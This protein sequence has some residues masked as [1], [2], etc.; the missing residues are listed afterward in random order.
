M[1]VFG[2][3]VVSDRQDQFRP[4]PDARPEADHAERKSARPHGV[5]ARRCARGGPG[6]RPVTARAPVHYRVSRGASAKIPG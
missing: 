1:L 2:K 5:A 4:Q 3:E 6:R